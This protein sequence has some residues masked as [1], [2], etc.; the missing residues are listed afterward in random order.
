MLHDASV[1]VGVNTVHGES[2]MKWVM[3]FKK[4]LDHVSLVR[5]QDE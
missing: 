3:H 4:G 1:D 5:V 2:T